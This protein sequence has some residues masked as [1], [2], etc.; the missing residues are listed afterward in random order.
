MKLLF[1]FA[2]LVL[3]AGCEFMSDDTT[4]IETYVAVEGTDN[5]TALGV[6]TNALP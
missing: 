6:S 3:L 1:G 4:N 5:Y 2:I